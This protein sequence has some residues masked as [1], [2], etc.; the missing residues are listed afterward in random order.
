MD[1]KDGLVRDILS[2]FHHII[3][4]IIAIDTAILDIKLEKVLMLWSLF[5]SRSFGFHVAIEENEV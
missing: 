3:H 5:R 4:T 2:I 1:R